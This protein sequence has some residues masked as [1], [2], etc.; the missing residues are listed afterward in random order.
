MNN[1]LNE[2][3]EKLLNEKFNWIGSSKYTRSNLDV[4]INKVF[5]DTK[6]K[7]K[8]YSLIFR[9]TAP[10]QIGNNFQI[11]IYKNRV[12]IRP[13]EEGQG[14]KLQMKSNSKTPNGYAKLRCDEDTKELDKFIGDY[15]LKYDT[16]YELYYIEKEGMDNE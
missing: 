2:T 8:A 5:W 13:V 1:N 10:Q 7:I 9:N 11:A 6:Q 12:M 14:V 15:E 16:F 3:R 4:S